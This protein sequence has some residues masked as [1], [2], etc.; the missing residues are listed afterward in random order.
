MTSPPRE[1]SGFRVRILL[2]IVGVV[3]LLVAAVVAGLEWTVRRELTTSVAADLD[4][5]SG[6]LSDRMRQARDRLSMVAKIVADE[7]RLKAA[8]TTE[9]IDRATLDDMAGDLRKTTGW[10]LVAL[11]G[12]G[13]DVLALSGTPSTAGLGSATDYWRSGSAVYRLGRAKLAFGNQVFATLIA[14]E[15]ISDER[16]AEVIKGSKTHAVLFDGQEMVAASLP[17]D[18]PARTALSSLA[19]SSG[20]QVDLAGE[21]FLSRV[22][23]LGEGSSLRAVILRSG[24]TVLAP[25]RRL[26]NAIFLIGAGVLALALAVGWLASSGLSRPVEQLHVRA[27]TSEGIAERTRAEMN[28][29]IDLVPDAICVQVQG[30]FVYANRRMVRLLGKNSSEELVGQ[31]VT[32]VIAPDDRGRFE[33]LHAEL[34]DEEKSVMPREIRFIDVTGSTIPME[35]IGLPI[36]FTGQQA[37]LTVAHDLSERKLLQARVVADKLAA[38]ELEVARSI[39]LSMVPPTDRIDRP[40]VKLAGYFEPAAECGG[41]WWTYH[42]LTGDRLLVVIGDVTGHG[43]PSAMMTAAVK[44][45]VDVLCAVYENNVTCPQVL[46]IMN[47]AICQIA[48]NKL[49]MTCFASIIDPAT[50]T[51]TFANAAHD[52]PILMR[53]DDGGQTTLSSLVGQGARLGEARGAAFESSSLSL[54][55]GD[56]ICWYTDGLIEDDNVGRKVGGKRL[57]TLLR[58]YAHLDPLEMRDAILMSTFRAMAGVK[59]TDDMTL[60]VAKIY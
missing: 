4:G 45:A 3:L 22:V 21:R 5:A 15:R 32:D 6:A 30:R 26:R 52:F 11:V 12:P 20:G 39:Q 31:R 9:G 58:T 50:R 14:G 47:E 2:S 33:A 53:K 25:Y 18:A 40:F 51:I 23:V 60:V 10:D 56:G 46:Q 42:D 24:D 17:A 29:L 16:L 1:S 7:P 49:H 59:R 43:I 27:L 41:D 48:G 54:L 44:A 19:G 38:K 8:L 55:P 28:R 36:D 57:R 37:T 35:V 13:G 34:T